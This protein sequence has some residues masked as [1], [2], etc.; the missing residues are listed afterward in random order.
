[1]SRRSS[2][3]PCVSNSPVGSH[4]SS[5][6]PDRDCNVTGMSRLQRGCLETVSPDVIPLLIE[7]IPCS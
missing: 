3:W 1:M 4:Y 7:K 6:G 2:N 5:D